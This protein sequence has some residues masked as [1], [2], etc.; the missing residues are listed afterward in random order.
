MVEAVLLGKRTYKVGVHPHNLYPETHIPITHPTSPDYKTMGG[1]A[2][3]IYHIQLDSGR[4]P[5]VGVT[6]DAPVLPVITD[7]RNNVVS[8]SVFVQCRLRS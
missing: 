3:G 1:P 7:G 2:T 5:L 4:R 8:P 6:G